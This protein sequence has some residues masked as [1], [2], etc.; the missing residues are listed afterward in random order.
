MKFKAASMSSKE[1]QVPQRRD[2]SL[3][4]MLTDTLIIHAYKPIHM[5]YHTGHVGMD[6][7]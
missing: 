3:I 6:R 5:A 1:P 2:E 7:M 4:R